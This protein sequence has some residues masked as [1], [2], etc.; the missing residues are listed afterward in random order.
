[1]WTTRTKRTPSTVGTW[2][3]RPKPIKWLDYLYWNNNWIFAI[4]QDENWENISIYANS[5]YEQVNDWTIRTR[6][7]PV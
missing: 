2:T 1:M 4:I 3:I 7:T 6:R 5:W